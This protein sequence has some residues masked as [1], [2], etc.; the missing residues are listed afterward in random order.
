[1]RF[2]F[3]LSSPL[4]SLRGSR[5]SLVE[6]GNGQLDEFSESLRGTYL[7]SISV[8]Y[9]LCSQNRPCNSL[10]YTCMFYSCTIQEFQVQLV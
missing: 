3:F 5:I 7:S 8:K 6:D 2:V 10:T 4:G 9:M 1:M